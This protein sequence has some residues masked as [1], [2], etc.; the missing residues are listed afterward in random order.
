M[1]NRE[2]AQ[3][4]ASTEQQLILHSQMQPRNVKPL[5]DKQQ[6]QIV[7][8]KFHS[9]F[10]E[11]SLKIYKDLYNGTNFNDSSSNQ[12]SYKNTTQNLNLLITLSSN[13]ILLIV[14]R[15]HRMA[16]HPLMKLRW[17]F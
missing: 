2:D 17:L 13:I 3:Y 16:N 14:L 8:L 4:P 5:T 9:I 6:I 7:L 12:V 11:F 1:D 10:S 15:L